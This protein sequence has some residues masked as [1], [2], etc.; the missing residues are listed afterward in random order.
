VTGI[1]GIGRDITDEQELLAE[2]KLLH[3]ALGNLSQG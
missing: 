3:L 1:H 2:M